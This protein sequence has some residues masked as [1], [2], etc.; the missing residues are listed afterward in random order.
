M[1]KGY[2][3]KILQVDL[4][5]GTTECLELAADFYRTYLGGGAVGAYF[6]LNGTGPET[7]PLGEENILTLAP[8]ITT[9]SNVSGVSRCSAVALSPLTGAVGEGQAGGNIGPMIKKAGY[10]AIVIKGKAQHLS[11]L[12]LDNNNVEIRDAGELK[13]KKV[14]EVF[15]YFK[16]LLE[17]RKFSLIQ[18]GPA[19]ENRVRFASLMVDRN[20]VVGRTGLGAVLGS[21]NLRA[22]VVSGTGTV[23]FHDPEAL[24][25]YNRVAKERLE[26]SGFTRILQ[27]HGTPGV[28]SIQA[29]A[30][31][32]ASFNYKSGFHKDHKNLDGNTYDP[33]I[34]AGKTTCPGCI[35][36][37]RKK[38]R[39]ESPHQVSDKLGGPEFET[40]SILGTNLDITEA[41][42]VARANEL[43][44]E[45][46]LDTITMGAMAAYL[47]EAVA[48]K[49]VKPGI[50]IDGDFRFGHPE[51]LF[52]LIELVTRRETIGNILAEGF[53]S[54]IEQ[55]G[56]NTAP[57]AIHCKGQGL[58]AHM[59]QVKPSQALMYAA[60]P[61][62][63]DHMSAEHDWFLNPND[64]DSRALGI[65]GDG[66]NKSTN[67]AKVRMTVYSQIYYS[68]LDTLTLCMFVWG[69]GNLHSYR[70]LE[71]LVTCSTGWKTS[72]WELMKVGERKINM[73]KQINARRGFTAKDD[74][75]PDR[76]YE[77]IAEGPS[78]GACVDRNRFPEM[79]QE[80]YGFMGWDTISGNPTP[81]K[82]M[83]LGLN[84]I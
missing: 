78:K 25:T 79:L 76:L 73:M 58:P 41:T 82:L 1:S 54:A 31:N 60:C 19:G 27:R 55:L 7:D 8:S 11:Y 33:E 64:Q 5:A 53:T 69:P 68:L 40:L 44:N 24:K 16:R 32:I 34:G 56:K 62:G 52:R 67:M 75:L 72:L 29:A 30:G 80:Y 81:G 83:E 18:C 61:I 48:T 38:V 50:N 20:N 42:A 3:G 37:C 59:A 74:R 22:V 17:K 28:V 13:Q 51:D 57:Y 21:K 84:P 47:F 15:D 35:I 65:F 23:E 39:A 9:G 43:C 77:P 36:A 2:C 14:S 66:N 71:D 10:D 45:A 70:E 63:G 26:K 49:S 6:L 12:Y 46:G 4:T